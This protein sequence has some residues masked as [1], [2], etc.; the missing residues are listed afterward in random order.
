MCLLYTNLIEIDTKLYKSTPRYYYK[1]ANSSQLS[2]M[3]VYPKTIS[4]DFD[5]TILVKFYRPVLKTRSHSGSAHAFRDGLH[6]LKGPK[7]RDL[8]LY[9]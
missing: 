5:I 1:Y 2:R 9:M 3:L 8:K 4:T 6:I 7:S